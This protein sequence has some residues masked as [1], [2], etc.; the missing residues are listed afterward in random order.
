MIGV[1]IYV[2]NS[3]KAV[4][5][6]QEAFHL[7]LGYHVL[8]RDGTYFHS[9]LTGNDGPFLSVSEAREDTRAR[10]HPVELGVEFD[11][12][13]A[14]ANA[15]TL[16]AAG[17]RVEMPLSALPWSPLAAIV[18]DEFSVRWFLSLPQH[19]PPEDWRCPD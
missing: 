18:I 19:R 11:T 12:R 4:K 10:I 1:G 6:Y 9:E 8:N 16:L 3:P 15:F 2:K 5:L 14:L 17:G 13:E 7:T